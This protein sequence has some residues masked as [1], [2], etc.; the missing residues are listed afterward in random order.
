M[1]SILKEMP[2]N[3]FRICVDE[4]QTDIAGKVYTPLSASAIEFNGFNE[5][6]V[7]LDKIFDAVGYPEAFQ[8]K[9]TFGALREKESAYHGMPKPQID[10]TKICSKCG[11]VGT[12]DVVVA[13]RRNT[14]W[15]GTVYDVT[16]H[17]LQSFKGE[18]ELLEGILND[19]KGHETEK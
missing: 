17:K 12:Y 13:A 7:K 2:I 8:E 3:G 15:Q 10:K 19:L 11:K 4:G 9:R 18:I 6:L 16:G 5:L 1:D 14:S